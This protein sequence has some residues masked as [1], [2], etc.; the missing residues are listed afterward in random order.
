MAALGTVENEIKTLPANLQPTMLRIFRAF[1]RD[2]RFGHPT[3]ET[4][5]PLVNFGGAFLY[6]TTPSAPGDTVTIA[7]GFGRTPYLAIAGLR[8]D[9]VGS[10]IVP[11]T[12]QRAADD[13][14][15][16]LTSTESDAPF[17]LLVEG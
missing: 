15:I 6:G 8:L 2:L 9:A 13:K 4:N 14:R 17:T 16:Y 7:H 12:V 5:D 1:L 3:G 11:L 10:S